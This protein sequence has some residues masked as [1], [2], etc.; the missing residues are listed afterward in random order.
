MFTSK[1]GGFEAHPHMLRLACGYALA[2]KVTT[3]A[4]V[5][6][7]SMSSLYI[8]VSAASLRTRCARRRIRCF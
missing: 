1:R 3:R 8:S 5:Q 2:S 6:S 7:W 4:L